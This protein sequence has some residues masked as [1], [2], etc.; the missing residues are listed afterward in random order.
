MISL[1]TLT[2]TFTEFFKAAEPRLRNALV[3]CYG[4]EVGREAAADQ[5]KELK[6]A[7]RYQRDVY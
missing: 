5:L 6:R 1:D 7:R 3:A 2:D 4:V